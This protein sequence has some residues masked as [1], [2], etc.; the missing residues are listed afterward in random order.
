MALCGYVPVD[1]GE[2]GLVADLV[3]VFLLEQ[4][5][6]KRVHCVSCREEVGDK[7]RTKIPGTAGNENFEAHGE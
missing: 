1:L 3:P 2:R 5:G 6:V 4:E 7:V